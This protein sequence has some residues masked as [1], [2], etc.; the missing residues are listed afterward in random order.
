MTKDDSASEEDVFLGSLESP[1][2]QTQ[3]LATISL[4]KKSVKF[5]LDTGAK[6][7]AISEDTFLTLTDTKLREPTKAFMTQQGPH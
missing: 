2:R 1:D 4:N 6:V 5:K 3:W 7:T